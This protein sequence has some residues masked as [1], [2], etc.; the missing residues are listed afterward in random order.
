MSNVP[1]VCHM[2]KMEKGIV[3]QM[4]KMMMETV[5]RQRF[6]TA[7]LRKS[8]RETDSGHF[9]HHKLPECFQLG[10]DS[11]PNVPLLC[12]LAQMVFRGIALLIA[13]WLCTPSTQMENDQVTEY[14]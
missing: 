8:T 7:R 10:N 1:F 14:L 9:Q 4:L 13:D 11:V 3:R 5:R 2:G 6:Q 12:L